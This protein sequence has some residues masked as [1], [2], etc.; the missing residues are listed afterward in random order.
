[1]LGVGKMKFSE[2]VIDISKA[3]PRTYYPR[4]FTTEKPFGKTFKEPSGTDQTQ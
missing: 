4:M 2:L 3:P 1:M